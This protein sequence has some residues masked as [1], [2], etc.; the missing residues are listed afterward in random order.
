LYVDLFERSVTSWYICNSFF[1][2]LFWTLDFGLF[3]T[4]GLS[5]LSWTFGLFWTSGPFW[6]EV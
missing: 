1:R 4:S 3:W 2:F 5:G 6:A